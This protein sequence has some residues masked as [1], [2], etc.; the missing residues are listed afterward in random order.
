MDIQE[1]LKKVHLIE[2]K[3][4]KVVNELLAGEYQS[5]FK[6]QGMEFMDVRPYQPGDD[7][8]SIDW[9]V[10]SRTGTVHIKQFREER[11]QTLLFAVDVSGSLR[12]STTQRLMSE[13]L[14][15]VTA[16]LAFSAIRNQD[17]VGM[18][19]ISDRIELFVPT[20]KGR[21]HVLRLIRE[22]IYFTPEGRRTN[23]INAL[24]AIT[25]LL[26]RRATV[27]L[28][29]D[30][31]GMTSTGLTAFARRHDVTAISVTDPAELELPASGWM[32]W[33]DPESGRHGWAP[34]HSAKLRERF[35]SLQA[36]R[37]RQLEQMFRRS[38][39]DHVSLST[40]QDVVKPLVLY[41]KRRERRRTA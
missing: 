15:E 40:S 14:A 23:F 26:P 24:S 17:R 10:T 5:A 31:I 9:N 18:L 39:I 28:C 27:F 16:L 2:L 4:R 1:I 33:M 20:R 3:T 41:F 30:F 36:R 35:H 32:E 19:L 38:A 34:T 25:Q 8:R 29:S 22:I 21:E 37:Q 11:E 12:F 7:F 6:G 13:L